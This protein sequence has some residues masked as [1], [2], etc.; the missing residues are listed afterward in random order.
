MRHFAA[1]KLA[2]GIDKCESKVRLQFSAAREF[3]AFIF[4]SKDY[5]SLISSP[6][7]SE[8][9]VRTAEGIGAYAL[10]S[11]VFARNSELNSG[12]YLHNRGTGSG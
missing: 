6:K 12:N 9:P 10:I 1:Q 8:G 5:Y 7:V 4:L 11:R 3:F 2:T